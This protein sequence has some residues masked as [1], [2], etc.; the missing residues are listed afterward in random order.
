MKHLGSRASQLLGACL[1][2][3]QP[4]HRPGGAGLSFFE[5]SGALAEEKELFA[6]GNQSRSK[7]YYESNEEELKH[8]HGVCESGKDGAEGLAHLSGVL[9]SGFC[10]QTELVLWEN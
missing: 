10:G 7:P 1:R 2:T 4:E 8:E 9:W 6:H 5:R 3:C